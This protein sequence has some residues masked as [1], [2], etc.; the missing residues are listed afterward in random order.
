[1]KVLRY[2]YEQFER[3]KMSAKSHEI[4]SKFNWKKVVKKM[5]VEYEDVQY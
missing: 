2:D 5:L 1:M 4:A 3:I